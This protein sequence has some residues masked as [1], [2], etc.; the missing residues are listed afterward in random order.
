[1]RKSSKTN[2]EVRLDFFARSFWVNSQKAF[3]DVKLFDINARRYSKQTLKLCY[4]LNENT[5][6]RQ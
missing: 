4:S 1:M 5:K 6:K 2:D 3:F